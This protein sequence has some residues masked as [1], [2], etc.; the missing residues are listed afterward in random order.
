[1][2]GRREIVVT[3]STSFGLQLVTP[4]SKEP[5]IAWLKMTGTP[6]WSIADLAVEPLRNSGQYRLEYHTGRVDPEGPSTPDVMS[7]VIAVSTLQA[8]WNETT[9]WQQGMGVWCRDAAQD[10]PEGA[11]DD[12]YRTI[13][14]WPTGNKVAGA[15]L[16]IY[17]SGGG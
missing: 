5:A 16:R 6:G 14:L 13:I 7:L 11:T 8:E 12:V 15:G 4:S 2:Y 17:P 3:A 1:M 10:D 9:G